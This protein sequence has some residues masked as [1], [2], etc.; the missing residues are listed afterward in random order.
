VEESH[1]ILMTKEIFGGLDHHWSFSESFACET[2]FM[3]YQPLPELPG[4]SRQKPFVPPSCNPA[5][6]SP[7]RIEASYRRKSCPR[8][9][10]N[11]NLASLGQH[12]PH[13][14]ACLLIRRPAWPAINGVSLQQASPIRPL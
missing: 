12:E 5:C 3:W 2:I 8:G 6:P 1:V 4:N 14:F 9:H 11:W 13:H 7:S 10:S